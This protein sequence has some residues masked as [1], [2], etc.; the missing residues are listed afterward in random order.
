MSPLGKCQYVKDEELTV[1]EA[2]INDK[3]KVRR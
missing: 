2:M 3:R 1:P